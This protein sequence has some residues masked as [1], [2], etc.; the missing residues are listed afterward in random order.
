MHDFF[1][2][3]LILFCLKPALKFVGKIHWPIVDRN[4][5][6]T[7]VDRLTIEYNFKPG[8]ILLSRARGHATNLLIPTGGKFWTHVAMISTDGFVIEAVDPAVRIV[9]LKFWLKDKDFVSLQRC[10][11][12]TEMEA[13]QAALL[14]KNFAGIGYDYYFEPTVHAMY[15]AEG[16]VQSYKKIIPEIICDPSRI[17]GVETFL[18]S[19]FWRSSR[20]SEIYTSQS[21]T[22]KLRAKTD[23][24]SSVFV[25]HS[26]TPTPAPETI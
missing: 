11:E 4:R 6:L 18:P 26:T 1:L 14:F 22:K 2:R 8:D 15:C 12:A 10:K 5:L 23:R 17:L 20:W 13:K 19:S 3:D 24:A 25:D 7:L 9:P 16:I 21:F